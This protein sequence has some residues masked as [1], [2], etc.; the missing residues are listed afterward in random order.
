MR[1]VTAAF[2]RTDLL[3]LARDRFLLG[4]LLM[5]LG[6][7]VAV[8]LILPAVAVEVEA[9]DLA[10]LYPLF[11][12]YVVVCVASLMGGAVGGFLLLESR[13]EAT[14]RALAVTPVSLRTYLVLLCGTLVV[15]VAALAIVQ[16]AAIGLGLPPWWIVLACGLCGSAFAPVL[17]LLLA[18]VAGNKVEAFAIMKI[19]GVA[20]M[21]P[22][23]AWFLPE[24]WQWTCAF[25]PPFLVSKAWWLA[26]AGAGAWPLWLLASIPVTAA[27]LLLLGRHFERVAV[28]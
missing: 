18:G 11:V 28:R 8:R 21:I 17:A 26:E 19:L 24:T 20:G 6:L 12:S 15:S 25:Y 16:A 14:I 27:Y 22:L 7:A 2:L 13:E 3:R 10:E 23:G 4:L 1:R 9:V 5:A